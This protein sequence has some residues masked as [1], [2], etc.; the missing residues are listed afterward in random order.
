[1]C[2]TRCRLSCPT[3]RNWSSCSHDGVLGSNGTSRVCGKEEHDQASCCHMQSLPCPPKLSPPL[4]GNA[5]RMA[6]AVVEQVLQVKAAGRVFRL[7]C[8]F[9]SIL[10]LRR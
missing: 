9:A 2:V 7:C 5:V 4:A 10:L 3:R 1:M 8:K 6:A